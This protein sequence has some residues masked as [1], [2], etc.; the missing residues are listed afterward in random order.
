M[1]HKPGNLGFE[2][3]EIILILLR[4]KYASTLLIKF[5][6]SEKY[7]FKLGSEFHLI[8]VLSKSMTLCRLGFCLGSY[9]WSDYYVEYIF[10]LFMPFFIQKY[11]ILKIILT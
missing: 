4:K 11:I 5:T 9:L 1:D 3:T 6:K 2:G 7:V 8:H 10:S